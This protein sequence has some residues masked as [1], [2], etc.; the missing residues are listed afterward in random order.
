MSEEM[1]KNDN[2]LSFGVLGGKSE[3][4]LGHRPHAT[5]NDEYSGK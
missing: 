4:Y 5:L 3:F 2:D 1:R